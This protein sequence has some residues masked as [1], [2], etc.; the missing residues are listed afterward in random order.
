MSIS[1]SIVLFFRGKKMKTMIKDFLKKEENRNNLHFYCEYA[2]TELEFGR[3][4]SCINILKSAVQ[5]VDAN[6][7]KLADSNNNT[8]IFSVYKTLCELYLRFEHDSSHAERILDVMALLAVAPDNT[9]AVQSKLHWIEKYF[10][11]CV[12][13]FLTNESV[14]TN[15][16]SFLPNVDCDIISCYAYIL[17]IQRHGQEHV[18]QI[19]DQ[20][21]HHTSQNPSLQ[22]Q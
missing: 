13:R 17:Y 19:L 4:D 20:C 2:M 7:L 5:S 3:I 18:L 11:Q 8:A 9:A 22:V 12:E 15:C 10:E 14:P 16:I 21:L 6:S 1:S